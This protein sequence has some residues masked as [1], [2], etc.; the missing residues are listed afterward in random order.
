MSDPC[1]KCE[2]KPQG[3]H[4][5]SCRH[6][7]IGYEYGDYVEEGCENCKNKRLKPIA[8]SSFQC[9]QDVPCKKCSRNDTITDKYE[10][11]T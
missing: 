2:F 7:I 3:D 5:I 4:C 10:A 9:V 11:L 8:N 6:Y 1:D